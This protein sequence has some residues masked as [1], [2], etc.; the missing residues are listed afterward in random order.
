MKK[1]LTY[2]QALYRAASLCSQGEKCPSD[3]Y[4]KAQEWG[5]SASDAARLV[6]WLTDERYLDEHRF[7]HAFINDKFT[8]QHW[9]RIKISYALRLKGINDSLIEDTMSEVIDPDAYLDTCVALLKT[10][11]KGMELPL[12]QADR[13]KVFRFAAQRGFESSVISKALHTIEK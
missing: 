4:E 5:L 6:R 10:K 2:D 7:V 3:I 12:S 11:V 9:G 1:S 13:A 8:Y